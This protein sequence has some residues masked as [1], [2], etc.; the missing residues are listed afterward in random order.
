M[1]PAQWLEQ[2]R[3]ALI[4]FAA[5]LVATPSPNPPGDERAVG[6]VI[7]AELQNLGSGSV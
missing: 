6:Q 1:I 3:E 4:G 2:R 7:L 5:K